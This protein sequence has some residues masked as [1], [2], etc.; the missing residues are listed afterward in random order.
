VARIAFLGTGI[1]GAHMARRLAA[2]GHAVTAWNRTAEKAA[3]L[4]A[5]GVG[6][7]V[8]PA[9]AMTGADHVVVMLSDAAAIDATLF[10]ADAAGRTSAD[11]VQRGALVIVSSSIPVAAAQDHA[12]RFVHRGVRYVDAPVSGGEG[13]ARDGTLAIFAG[14]D[15][16]DVDAVRALFAPLGRVTHMGAVGTG[17][18]TKLANQV[19]VAGTLLSVAEGLA[20]ARAGGADLAAVRDALSGGFTDSAVLRQHGERMVRGDYAPGSPAVQQRANLHN[21]AAQ[22]ASM[23]LALELLPLATRVFEAMCADGRGAQDVAAVFEQVKHRAQA[24]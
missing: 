10:A 15:A 14:G 17:Q 12:E 19:I 20:F 24:R 7:A 21:A 11:A 2:A 1:M 3:A 13:G 23:G 16:R 5:H 6:T 18:L 4:A 22:A 9:T 8:S